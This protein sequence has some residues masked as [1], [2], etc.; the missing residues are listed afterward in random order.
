MVKRGLI[1]FVALFCFSATGVIGAQEDYHIY[2]LLNN[3]KELKSR[4]EK[5]ERINTF[6]YG[7]AL[8][9]TGSCRKGLSIMFDVYKTLHEETKLYVSYVIARALF[10]CRSYSKGHGL[11]KKIYSNKNSPPLLKRV[12]LSLDSKFLERLSDLLQQEKVLLRVKRLFSRRGQAKVLKKIVKIEERLGKRDLAEKRMWDLAINYIS[13]KEGIRAFKRLCIESDCDLTDRQI[14]RIVRDLALSGKEVMLTRFLKKVHLKDKQ[15][16]YLS[17]LL[18]YKKRRYKRALKKFMELLR[19]GYFKKDAIYYIYNIYLKTDRE[20]EAIELMER[21]YQTYPKDKRAEKSLYYAAWYS[22]NNGFYKKA[23]R[24]FARYIEVYKDG[25]WVEDSLW[26][27]GWVKYLRADYAGAFETFLY[28]SKRSATYRNQATYWAA[29]CAISLG[30][31]VTARSLLRSVKRDDPYYYYLARRLLN[32]GFNDFNPVPLLAENFWGLPGSPILH[33]DLYSPLASE[34]IEKYIEKRRKNLVLIE[35]NRRNYSGFEKDVDTKELM[36]RYPVLVELVHLG[37]VDWGGYHARRVFKRLK[38]KDEKRHFALLCHILK[39]YQVSQKIASDLLDEEFDPA[40]I[41]IAYPMPY[42]DTVKDVS[43][44]FEIDPFLIFSVIRAESSFRLSALSPVGAVGLMQL[45]PYTARRIERESGI[46]LKNMSLFHPLKNLYLASWY[47]TML[48]ENYCN[49]PV[50]A[51]AAYNAG[52]RVLNEW[53]SKHPDLTVDEFVEEISY[54]E[55]RKYVKN[56]IGNYAIY[57]EIYLN[58]TPEINLDRVCKPKG[59]ID[60]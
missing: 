54:R 37:L 13:T 55:T 39:L 59:I 18:D 43:D 32:K 49:N 10:T 30:S 60:F 50:F 31:Y 38:D 41:K 56:V 7:L 34:M 17:A 52:P 22:Y 3:Y 45:M 19:H 23:L 53:I 9:R 51:A 14:W 24:L 21:F 26:Y 16:R 27:T 15:K 57:L 42:F 6:L 29:R 47:L 12:A 46:L 48:L 40:M 2:Y 58:Q 8:A 35:D 25:R 11:L 1:I 36:D 28:L 5:D 33:P 4:L 20:P 44:T